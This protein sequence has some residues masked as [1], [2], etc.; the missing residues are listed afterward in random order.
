MSLEERMEW[1]AGDVVIY[2]SLA[3]LKAKLRAEGKQFIP[4]RPELEPENE[5]EGTE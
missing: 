2:R 5:E 1:R 4:S 3:E